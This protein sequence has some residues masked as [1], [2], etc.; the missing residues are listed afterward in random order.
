MN[1]ENTPLEQLLASPTANLHIS[2]HERAVLRELATQV[3][4]LAAR[5]I[6]QTKRDLWLKHNSLQ[7][8]RPLVFCDPE[9][10]WFE[11]IPLDQLNCKGQLART[12]EFLLLREIFWGEQMQDDRVI[13]PTFAVPHVYTETD[14]GMHET[15]IGGENG[16]SYVWDSPLKSYDDLNKLH[17]P[18]ITVDEQATAAVLELAQ[19]T[20]GD[21]LE[22]QLKTSWLW[23]WGMTRTL[24]DL[25]G[26]QQI[27]LDMY[28]QP[29][30]LHRLMGILRDGHLAKLDFLENN[31]LL[32]L[33]NDGTYVGSGGFGWTDEL[34]Q[35]D[36]QDLVRAMDIWGFGES[37]E[38]IGVSPDMFAE[39]IFPYQLAI[40]ERFGLNCYGCCEPVDR[41]WSHIQQIPRLRRVSVSPWANIE[42]MADYLGGD[43]VFS[44]KP[45]PSMLAMEAV[46]EDTIRAGLREGFAK[47]RD[48]RVEVIMKDTH[49]IRRDPQRVIRWV[50]IALEEANAL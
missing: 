2:P 5:P 1:E 19:E 40:L 10:S 15:R 49:T 13:M 23:T 50:E 47:T 36:H 12:W 44:W 42:K 17:F 28:D 21:L 16:G 6:E 34:P 26:M 3:A 29:D 22:V 30:N 7:P 18:Q 48:C 38:T 41:R 45:N 9:N 46:D 35:S 11:I 8:T 32:S 24:V 31:G 25:R 27:M 37:Q 20:L 4:E 39:F 14:W 33:N 43:Y